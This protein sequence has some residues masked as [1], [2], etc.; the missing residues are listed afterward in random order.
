MAIT[1]R[2]PYSLLLLLL[3][4]RFQIKNIYSCMILTKYFYLLF[5]FLNE[6]IS[7]SLSLSTTTQ[8]KKNRSPSKIRFN[9]F[10]YENIEEEERLYK[11]SIQI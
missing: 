7:H 3:N 1:S 5:F 4:L 2:G 11:K 10:Y 9:F 6:R 8:V